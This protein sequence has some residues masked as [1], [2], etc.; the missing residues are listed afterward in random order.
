MDEPED[1]ELGPLVMYDEDGDGFWK[2][3]ISMFD[4]DY[5]FSVW[6]EDGTALVEYEETLSWRGEI[7]VKEPQ[8][9]VWQTLMV[10]DK[11]TE[12]LDEEGLDGVRRAAPTP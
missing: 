12:L 11:M 10:S 2:F 7:R 9:E 4:E 8:E 5:R 1:E 3:T 6:S